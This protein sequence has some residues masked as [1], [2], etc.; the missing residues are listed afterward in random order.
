LRGEIADRDAQ[1]IAKE[2]L[3]ASQDE[4]V[5]ALV[6]VAAED[7]LTGQSV[8][9]IVGPGVDPEAVATTVAAFESAGASIDS[10]V[11]LS[12]LWLSPEHIA[13][14]GALAEQIIADVGGIQP[15]ASTE[16]VLSGAL[17][18][19]LVPAAAQEAS[20]TPEPDEAPLDA[21]VA[22][23]R[24]AVLSDLLTRA[25]LVEI[26]GQTPAT[27]EP[28]D[29]DGEPLPGPSV[30]VV[31]VGDEPDA[32]SRAAASQQLVRLAATFAEADLGT[33]L[34]SGAPS[35]GDVG[36]TVAADR[37]GAG[38]ASVVA[39]AFSDLGALVV[40][41]AVQEQLSGGAG[42]YGSSDRG[43]LVPTP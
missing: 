38:G 4:L 20:P 33:V 21:A 5:S 26:H 28:A 30:A 22:A 2:R 39:N 11:T 1:L 13:F 12:P 6:P 40:V 10:T 23:Q 14:R 16:Q 3:L 15:G 19:A 43:S 42:I 27:G 34:A 35:E 25:E 41:L 32:D 17:V 37:A 9:L 36:A 29:I 31:L 8:A 7:R 24:S 18:Q